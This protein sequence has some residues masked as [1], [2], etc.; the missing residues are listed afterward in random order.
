MGLL[1]KA[2][3]L[4]Y[5]FRFLTLLVTPF[6]KT[7]A[8]KIGIIDSQGKVLRKPVTPEEKDTFTPFHKL[9]FNIKKLMAKVPGGGSKIA[10]YAAALYLIKEKYSL[11]DKKI[12]KALNEA[13]YD[14]LDLIQEQ[15][16]WFMLEDN[17]LAPGIYKVRNSKVLND[18]CEELVHPNDKIRVY[19][20]TY[21]VGDVFGIRIYEAVHIPTRQK[22]YVSSGELYR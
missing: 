18:T 16:E 14:T 21:P 12:E 17:Q 15:S 22:I 8:Y 13:G 19:D 7:D 2:G 3:D 10:S 11:S 6:E 9:V 1:K 20:D 4:V 5:T